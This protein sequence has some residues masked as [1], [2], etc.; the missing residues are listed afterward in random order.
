MPNGETGRRSGLKI[1]IPERVV[2]GGKSRGDTRG[3]PKPPIFRTTLP[4]ASANPIKVSFLIMNLRLA[5]LALLV[6][7]LGSQILHAQNRPTDTLLVLSK[8]GQTLAIVDPSSLKA[9]VRIPVGNDPHE[10]IASTDGKTAYVSNYGFGAYNTLAVVD[11]VGQKALPSIDLGALRDPH[12]LDFVGGK[13]WFKIGRAS[14]RER[15]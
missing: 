10:V 8:S 1:R 7:I 15:V 5:P 3:Y 6:G 9:I 4:L 13:V 12:G 14:C 2:G 11:L